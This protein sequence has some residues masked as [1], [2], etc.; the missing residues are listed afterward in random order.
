MTRKTGFKNPP[1]NI[2]KEEPPELA[3]MRS[4]VEKQQQ[5]NI[6]S[7]G[8]EATPDGMKVNPMYIEKR[9]KRVQIV[10]QPSLYEQL[11]AHAKEIGMSF[12]SYC[13]NNSLSI[14]ST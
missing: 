2:N 11:K 3:F 12:N 4:S 10:L 7:K 13:H 8:K 1:I 9:T 5:D 6:P 14:F